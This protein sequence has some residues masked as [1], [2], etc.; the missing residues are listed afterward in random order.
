M[1]LYKDTNK[2]DSNQQNIV[3]NELHELEKGSLGLYEQWKC[4]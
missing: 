3:I 1:Q 4:R 2:I